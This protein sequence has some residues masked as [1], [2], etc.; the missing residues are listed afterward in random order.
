MLKIWA[1]GG[2]DNLDITDVIKSHLIVL[3]AENDFKT[4]K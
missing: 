3:I 4:I 2:T 1:E